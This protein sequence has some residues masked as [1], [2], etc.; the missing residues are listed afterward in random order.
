MFQMYIFLQI[1]KFI[2]KENFYNEVPITLA[3]TEVREWLVLTDQYLIPFSIC[4]SSNFLYSLIDNDPEV[5]VITSI[6]VKATPFPQPTL[7]AF[8]TASLIAKRDENFS[9]ALMLNRT[10]FVGDFFI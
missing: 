9:T 5:S 1:T 2:G 6:S 10:G 3:I 7:K 8:I 4:I